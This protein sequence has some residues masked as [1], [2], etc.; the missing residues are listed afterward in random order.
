[1]YNLIEY[2]HSHLRTFGG[3]YQFC[4]DESSKPVT[5]SDLFKFKLKNFK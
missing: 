3:L 1:M 2:G 4:R 5:N